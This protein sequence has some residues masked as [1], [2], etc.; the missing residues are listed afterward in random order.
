MSISDDQSSEISYNY[1]PLPDGSIRL[2]HLQPR[3]VSDF[4][5]CN[6][7]AT[8]VED[9]MPAFEALSYTWGDLTITTAISCDGLSLQVH[10]NAWHALSELRHE[11]DV[12]VLWIDALCINQEDVAERNVQVQMMR[13]I[14]GRASCVLV[15][16]GRQMDHTDQV[17]AMISK[18]SAMRTI[19]PIDHQTVAY[20][21]DDLQA[22]DLPVASDPVW[23]SLD[24]L[25][26]SSWFSRVWIIQEISLA[27]Q[28]RVFSGSASCGW[29]QLELA[30]RYI[31]DHS[32]TMLVDVDPSQ[33]IRLARL[34]AAASHPGTSVLEILQ[35]S[36][37]SKSTDP[38]DKI[39][40]LLGL[41]PSF[42]L[43]NPDYN[44]ATHAVHTAFAAKLIE[45]RQSLDILNYTEIWGDYALPVDLLDKTPSWAPNWSLSGL[46][47]PLPATAELNPGNLISRT[48]PDSTSLQVW[49]VE[50][51][52]IDRA[53]DTFLE[54]IPRPGNSV[55]GA[56]FANFTTDAYQMKRWR[57]WEHMSRGTAHHHPTGE[58]VQE[59]YLRTI[60]ANVLPDGANDG[61]A[62]QTYY[63]S[64][65]RF[66]RVGGRERGRYLNA[67]IQQ[68]NPN[69]LQ[70]A[71]A[72]M[73]THQAA[74]YGR[75]FLVTK[76]GYF[77]LGPF[78]T[79]RGDVVVALCGGKTAYV[80]RR[81][82]PKGPSAH[83]KVIGECYLHGVDRNIILTSAD[84]HKPYILR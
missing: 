12:R 36:R 67:Y 43:I 64:W 7:V 29:S 35:E 33:V 22:C 71:L 63:E 72:F 51:G 1:D 62:L 59:A 5:T 21:H 24:Q 73:E 44:M 28:A 52:T 79:R 76:T 39:F 14:Y 37:S 82:S 40:G 45:T 26:W 65:L 38:R 2:L 70:Q 74:A 4:I 31:D 6:L 25:L 68:S 11:Q 53:G 78:K 34:K 81:Q 46:T 23:K 60:V 83:W 9:D 18:L 50:L 66:W 30:A 75:R 48:S 10:S 3:S 20:T 32:L 61:S 42:N 80:V 84:R 16:L 13:E 19:D 54:W 58:P 41:I 56:R 57:Q 55:R 17:F 15:W 47:R 49:G 8:H 27:R 69:E 77:G